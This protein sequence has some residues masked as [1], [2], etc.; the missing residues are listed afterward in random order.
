MDLADTTA[1]ADL[2][3]VV[4]VLV[5]NAGVQQVAP[6][7]EFP[8]DRFSTIVRLMLEAPFLLIRAALPAC[9]GRDSAES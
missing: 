5:N 4:D 1:L 2:S 9:T 7:E 3:L 8:P 6:I